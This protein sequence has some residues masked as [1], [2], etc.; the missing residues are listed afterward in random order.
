MNRYVSERSGLSERSD[1]YKQDRPRNFWPSLRLN[2]ELGAAVLV[3]L[4]ALAPMARAQAPAQAGAPLA[5]A[6]GAAIPARITQ[7]IDETNRI[8][9]R[10][11]THP[12]ARP[13]FDQGAVADS[14]PIS[15]ML[16]LLQRSPAQESA[17]KTLLDQQQSKSSPSY[18]QWLTPQQFGQQFGPADA[19]VAT[20]TGWL[21][22]HGFQVSGVAAGRTFI[23]FSGNAGQVRSAFNTEI[24]RYVVNGQSHLANSTD[25]QIPAALAP[26]VAGPVQLNN[27]AKKAQSHVRGSFSKSMDTG[28]VKPLFTGTCPSPLPCESVLGGDQYFAVGPADFAKIY[29]MTV[30]GNGNPNGGAGQTIAIV[31]DSDICTSGSPDFGSAC[32]GADDVKAFR[33]A[34]ELTPAT[35]NLNVIVN[36]TNPGLTFDEIEGDLDVEWSGAIAPNAT[37]D[38]V[39][40]QDTEASAGIDLAA[41]YIVDNN[42]APVMSESFGE[43]EAALG[44]D[45]NQFYSELW[46]QAAAQGITVII[47]A[48][49]SGSAGCDDDNTQAFAEYFGPGVNGI[50]S[51]PFN[52]SAGG[53]DFDITASGYPGT[54]WSTTNSTPGSTVGLS[55]KSYIPETTWNDSC[56]QNFTGILTSCTPPANLGYLNIVAGGG[57]QSNCLNYTGSCSEPSPDYTGSTGAGYPKPSWQSGAYVAGLGGSDSVRN[58]PD[59]SLFAADG[60]VSNSFYVVC[61]ADL[62]AECVSAV[63]GIFDFIGVGGTSSSAPTFAGIMALVNASQGR[64]GNAN[65]VLYPLANKQLS[66]GY[67]CNSS[68]TSVNT[69]Q[70]TF[71]DVTKGNNDVPCIGGSPDCN[72][73]NSGAYGVLESNSALA[74]NTAT[75]YDLATGLG[76]I[77]VANLIS[78]WSS[79]AGSFTG[80]TTTLCMAAAPAAASTCP[81]SVTITHGAAVNVTAS[82]TPSP[83]TSA[84]AKPETI[85]L[86]GSGGTLLGG[87]GGVNHFTSNAPEGEEVVSNAGAI[88]LTSG[89]ATFTTDFLEG[90]TY[91]VEARYAGDGTFGASTSAAPGVSVTVSPEPSTTTVSAG[92]LNFIR[93][94]IGSV[95]GATVFYGDA[96]IL[97]TDI[98]GKTSGQESASGTVTFLDNGTSIGNS[99]L[100]TEGYT[101]MQTGSNIDG[102]TTPALAVG[103]HSITATYGGDNSYC[104]SNACGS[105]DTSSVAFTVEAAPTTTSVGA[106]TAAIPL[107]TNITVASGTSVTLEAVV[108]TA[109][110]SGL[111]SGGSSGAFLTGNVAFTVTPQGGAATV[112]NVPITSNANT[113]DSDE[114]VAGV[115]TLNISPTVTTTV[116]AAFTPSGFASADYVT[117]SS[118]AATVTV[119]SSSFTLAP[120]ASADATITVKAGQTTGN[121]QP[122]TVTSTGLSG[123]VTLT[124]SVAAQFLT[125]IAD[126]PTC[127]FT[128][129]GSANNVVALT[130]SGSNGQRLLT[131]ATTAATTQLVP[132]RF[133]PSPNNF[134]LPATIVSLAAFL[135]LF[136]VPWGIPERRRGVALLVALLFVT[137]AFAVSCSGGGGGAAPVSGG[138]SGG[139]GN[140]GTTETAYTVTV[141]ATPSTGAAQTTTVQLIV[142]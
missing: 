21:Q 1:L 16:L 44:Q 106:S 56:A 58:L 89:A 2:L 54:Y 111:S 34:F 105:T 26:V 43:C 87:T 94:S 104:A 51:T 60:F 117:S 49:D 29:N 86:I 46:E 102:Y 124:C 85:S 72:V 82:V 91:T 61:E 8:T 141:T 35:P 78:N 45:A 139:G 42:L 36:G 79:V 47:S 101:E 17:L 90:G 23:E 140:V 48:G 18:R 38:F 70:C 40:A 120:L 136:F 138:G 121:T 131:I 73:T 93:D 97:R 25:P 41:E 53:T 50:G 142:N 68:S 128:L 15:R 37:V 118:S 81:G 74:F 62:G 129:S 69:A 95:S 9:L 119:S 125:T 116:T 80:T 112:T 64:Q 11:N 3:A 132:L 133:P 109:S 71:Y 103:A 122:I 57:G 96:L 115:A 27:F 24:H 127:S 20:V 98:V 84:A 99:A 134:F 5:A 77:N 31:G 137:G 59:I 114:F 19:D 32:G 126:A 55:A 75:S 6:Q 7:P 88:P 10:G 14:Q 130:G 63:H 108:D 100:N 113:Y 66:N 30:G 67:N 110:G 65:Y 123:N 76:T 4:G 135:L 52:V 92:L 22:S 13:Q 33:T 39:I 12:L 107:G 28:Q 83:G